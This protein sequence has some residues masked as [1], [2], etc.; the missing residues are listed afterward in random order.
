MKIGSRKIQTKPTTQTNEKNWTLYRQDRHTNRALSSRRKP[1]YA[2]KEKKLLPLL[3]SGVKFHLLLL[4]CTCKGTS[5]AY[6][7]LPSWLT[8]VIVFFFPIFFLNCN[9]PNVKLRGHE[10]Y[11]QCNNS[12]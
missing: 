11:E 10:P 4:V 5:N 8:T 7:C 12:Y 9:A 1:Q 6:V 2:G 3:M